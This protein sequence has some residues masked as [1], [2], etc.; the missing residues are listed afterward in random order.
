MSRGRALSQRPGAMLDVAGQDKG[1]EDGNG[2]SGCD[3]GPVG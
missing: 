1:R 3:Q 2:E